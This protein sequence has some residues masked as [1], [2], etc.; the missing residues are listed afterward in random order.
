[1]ACFMRNPKD[2]G[3]QI[4]LAQWIC[5]EKDDATIAP[6]LT[7]FY[8]DLQEHMFIFFSSFFSLWLCLWYVV[9]VFVC[10]SL[11]LSLSF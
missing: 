6:E 1:M 3:L 9:F 2:G 8:H 10:V 4:L 11:S 7:A 5:C